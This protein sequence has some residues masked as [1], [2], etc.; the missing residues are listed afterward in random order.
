MWDYQ[1]VAEI[2]SLVST[3]AAKSGSEC[4]ALTLDFTAHG[5][6]LLSG[7]AEGNVLIWDTEKLIQTS[8]T[9][10][11]SLKTTLSPI[12]SVKWL[13]YAAFAENFRF[14]ALTQDGIVQLF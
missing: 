7:D 12:I 14:V 10:E 9:M 4:S 3:F 6:F 8:G 13:S 2:N 1:R 11:N 5:D